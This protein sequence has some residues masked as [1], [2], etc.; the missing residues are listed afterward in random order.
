MS[1]CVADITRQEVIVCRR[2]CKH[3]FLPHKNKTK[4]KLCRIL[5]RKLS[6]HVHYI[7]TM[8]IIYCVAVILPV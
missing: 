5:K 8:G 2:E 6:K 1:M 7:T 3:L 4:Q